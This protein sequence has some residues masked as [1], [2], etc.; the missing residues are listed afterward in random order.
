[1]FDL[2]L[3]YPL[4]E[5][6]YMFKIS[7][8]VRRLFGGGVYLILGLTGAAFFRGRCLFNFW[9][10]WCGTYSRAVLNRVNVVSCEG[11]VYSGQN[12]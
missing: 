9:S 10:H 4:V 12:Y 6:V 7:T 3:L 2:F 11:W 5:M 8:R 1:M